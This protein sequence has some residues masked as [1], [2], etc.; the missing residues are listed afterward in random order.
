MQNVAAYALDAFVGSGSNP[1]KGYEN[2]LLP[3]FPQVAVEILH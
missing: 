3:D 1:V 2:F